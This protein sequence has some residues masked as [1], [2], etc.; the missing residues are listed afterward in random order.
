MYCTPPPKQEATNVPFLQ[1]RDSHSNGQ[2]PHDW[3]SH[4]PILNG[5]KEHL[6]PLVCTSTHSPQ[7]HLWSSVRAVLCPAEN[8]KTLCPN[9]QQQAV[10]HRGTSCQRRKKHILEQL[11]HAQVIATYHL[12]TETNSCGPAHELMNPFNPP[13]PLLPTKHPVRKSKRCY[14]YCLEGTRAQASPV[15]AI[16]IQGF[17]LPALRLSRPTSL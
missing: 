4:R 2:A 9:A 14:G 3:L 17:P 7:P 11:T 16:A 10:P 12:S 6:A 13:N 5:P 15:N 8:A 1:E